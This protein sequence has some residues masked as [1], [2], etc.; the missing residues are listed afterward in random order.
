MFL[1]INQKKYFL[2][3][4]DIKQLLR[5]LVKA[6]ESFTDIMLIDAIVMC[7][8]R[9]QPL[10]RP[11]SPIHKV[12]FFLGKLTDSILVVLSYF[13]DIN[14]EISF[15]KNNVNFISIFEWLNARGLAISIL[16]T[17]INNPKYSR[18][19]SGWLYQYYNWM[20]SPCMPLAWHCWNKIFTH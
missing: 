9:L 10:L 15:F 17:Y 12:I 8:T 20:R 13:L 19:Y 18:L 3:R 14:G 6:L 11:E 7:L 5:I 2:L 1:L 4:Q 16:G